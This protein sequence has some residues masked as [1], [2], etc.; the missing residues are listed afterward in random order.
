MAPSSAGR[1]AAGSEPCRPIRTTTMRVKPISADAARITA[2]WSRQ[3]THCSAEPTAPWASRV[4]GYR[5]VSDQSSAC[6]RCQRKRAAGC[7]AAGVRGS[8]DARIVPKLR[9]LELE[10]RTEEVLQDIGAEIAVHAPALEEDYKAAIAEGQRSFAWRQSLYL[11]ADLKPAGDGVTGHAT[12][13][14]GCGRNAAA[15]AADRGAAGE[16]GKTMP[17]A[18]AAHWQ[19]CRLCTHL[20]ASGTERDPWTG[21]VVPQRLSEALTGLSAAIDAGMPATPAEALVRIA[22]HC[23][24]HLHDVHRAAAA[25]ATATPARIASL[26]RVREVDATTMAWLSR[27][28]GETIAEKLGRQQRA[29]TLVRRPGPRPAREPPGRALRLQPPP[30]A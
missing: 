23:A 7:A 26:H 3:S 4:A 16:C 2:T 11:E 1:G 5:V 28:A 25:P 22:E 13:N 6:L 24:D 21:R 12:V 19:A 18:A 17:D 27:Q 9:G 30:I 20:M 14:A 15:C 10:G 29:L 8:G